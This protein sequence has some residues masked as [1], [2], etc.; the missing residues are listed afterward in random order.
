MSDLE[1][2]HKIDPASPSATYNLA[3]AYFALGKTEE[4]SSLS[5]QL[6]GPGADAVSEL[7]D[8]KLKSALGLQLREENR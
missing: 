1:L 3:R 5:K 7:S 8:Q 6:A 4:A 2:A